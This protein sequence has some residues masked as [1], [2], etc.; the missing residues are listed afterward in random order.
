MEKSTADQEFLSRLKIFTDEVTGA[1]YS[2]YAYLRTHQI[3]TEDRNLYK[4]ANKYSLFWITVLISLQTTTF[5]TLGRIFDKSSDSHSIDVL[6]KYCRDNKHIFSKEQFAK[7][8][9][10]FPHKLEKFLKENPGE[11]VRDT[12]FDIFKGQIDSYR[13]I[14]KRKYQG[15]RHKIY[16]HKDARVIGKEHELFSKTSVDEL[17]SILDFLNKVWGALWELYHNGRRLDLTK[18]EVKYVRRKLIEHTEGFLK[19]LNKID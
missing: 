3:L 6:I 5:I 13:D 12:D 9:A 8:K 18:T 4:K 2:F 10:A 1:E 17:K 14:F 11:L 16:A 19:S 15:I 7:R